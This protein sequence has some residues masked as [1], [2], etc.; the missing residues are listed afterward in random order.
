MNVFAAAANAL[1]PMDLITGCI[2]AGRLLAAGV[3][4]YGNGSWRRRS[5]GYNKIKDA[6]GNIRMDGT[7]SSDSSTYHGAGAGQYN[8]GAAG[9]EYMRGE[10]PVSNIN[11]VN[12][13]Y[14]P[15]AYHPSTSPSQLHQG[16]VPTHTSSLTPPTPYEGGYMENE[17]DDDLGA[18]PVGSYGNAYGDDQARLLDSQRSRSPGPAA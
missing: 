6:A 13:Q 15:P 3:G 16:T 14:A 2:Y 11:N 7:R 12:T 1:N 18:Q 8:N 10:N 5:G 4:P 9:Y 17:Y